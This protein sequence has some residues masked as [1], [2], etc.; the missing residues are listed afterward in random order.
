MTKKADY[1]V[2]KAW[3]QGPNLNYSLQFYLITEESHL[4]TVSQN[5]N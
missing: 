3:K 1:V 2:Y 5:I 4:A